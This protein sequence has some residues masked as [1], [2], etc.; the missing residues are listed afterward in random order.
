M[1]RIVVALAAGVNG[2]LW[3]V[4]GLFGNAWGWGWFAD[5]NALGYAC[6]SC[7]ICAIPFVVTYTQLGLNY[8]EDGTPQS[9]ETENRQQRLRDECSVWP[10]SWA[11]TQ[12]LIVV[13]LALVL[14][15]PQL[16]VNFF[17]VFFGAFSL[18]SCLWFLLVYPTARAL[19]SESAPRGFEKHAGLHHHAD[20]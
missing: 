8:A 3:V 17:F 15:Q 7:V 14:L 20:S 19:F 10:L 5:N 1:L 11:V 16:R 4:A 6:I 18:L 13:A 9:P 12:G 2:L